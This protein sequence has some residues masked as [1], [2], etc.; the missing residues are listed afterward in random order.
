MRATFRHSGSGCDL[1]HRPIH[2]LG[3]PA[4]PSSYTW[5]RSESSMEAQLEVARHASYSDCAARPHSSCH[6]VHNSP[7]CFR[8]SIITTHPAHLTATQTQA[9][10]Q[11]AE[12]VVSGTR[13][14]RAKRSARRGV[15]LVQPFR[16]SSFSSANLKQASKTAEE[17]PGY[18]EAFGGCA[19]K[20]CG[21]EFMQQ[22]S[23]PLESNCA[24]STTW[25]RRR[26]AA[27]DGLWSSTRCAQSGAHLDLAI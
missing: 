4:I 8:V 5:S 24:M 9:E 12:K 6:S 11:Y 2:I 15:G 7:H 26:M 18:A 19:Q 23:I 20:R 25:F 14:R 1:T 17:R 13:S 3:R 16:T 27:C 10:H 21:T 22:A